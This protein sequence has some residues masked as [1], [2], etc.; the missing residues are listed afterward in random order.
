VVRARL[1]RIALVERR[2]RSSHFRSSGSASN[3]SALAAMVVSSFSPVAWPAPTKNP[4]S[5]N[6]TRSIVLREYV[7]MAQGLPGSSRS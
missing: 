1:R 2:A 5:N 6:E 4:A 3:S 7:G